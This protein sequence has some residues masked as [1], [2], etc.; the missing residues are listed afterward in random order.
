[1]QFS[2]REVIENTNA[3][4]LKGDI[5]AEVKFNISTDTRKIQKGDFYLPLRGENYDGHCFIDNA[6][7]EGAIGYFT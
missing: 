7:N 2:I 4:L 6:I 1:M 3:A 5:E